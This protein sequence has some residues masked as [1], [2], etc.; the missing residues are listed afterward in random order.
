MSAQDPAILNGRIL[1]F[2][3]FQVSTQRISAFLCDSLRLLLLTYIYRR[4]AEERR[5]IAEKTSKVVTQGCGDRSNESTR[6]KVLPSRPVFAV[7]A[8]L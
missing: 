5:D 7:R 6:V 8:I 1:L 4:D 3:L 2:I